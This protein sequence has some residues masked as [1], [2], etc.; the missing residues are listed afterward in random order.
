MQTF[1]EEAQSRKQELKRKATRAELAFGEILKSLRIPYAFQK[2][3][4]TENRYFILD[5]VIHMTPKLVVEIDGDSHLGRAG[6]D[7][8]R[9]KLVLRTKVYNGFRVLR[10]RNEQVF[11]G[12]AAEI[13]AAEYPRQA[14]RWWKIAA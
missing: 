2:L 11:T 12:E 6:Y 14:Q 3:V 10:I 7:A 13:I 9:T 1:G 5:F 8:T 4:F